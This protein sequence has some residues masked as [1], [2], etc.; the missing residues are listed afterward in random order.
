MNDWAWES[1]NYA[2]KVAYGDLPVAVPIETPV[3]TPTC[4]ADND[5]AG[6]MLKLHIVV[7]EPYQ[8]AA[9]KVVE[10]RLAQGGIRLAMILNDAAKSLQ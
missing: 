2:N 10:L 3:P 1:H 4:A 9:A 8:E 7:G 6:R 5:I